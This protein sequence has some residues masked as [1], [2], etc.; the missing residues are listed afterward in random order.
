M[1]MSLSSCPHM[2]LWFFIFCSFSKKIWRETFSV[3]TPES[4]GLGA[5]G[6]EWVEARDAVQHPPVHRRATNT[7]EW[8]SLPCGWCRGWTTLPWLHWLICFILYPLA[9]SPLFCLLPFCFLFLVISSLSQ[10]LCS[11]QLLSSFSDKKKQKQK[12]NK[13]KTHSFYSVSKLDV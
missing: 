3:V 5:T 4:E 12:Q 6:M 10:I 1:P 9:P 13:T 7:I 8:S 11:I 2:F